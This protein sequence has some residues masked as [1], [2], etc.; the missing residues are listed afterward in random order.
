M[1]KAKDG[2]GIEPMTTRTA[3]ERSTAELS[4]LADE[5]EALQYRL[6]GINENT[7]GLWRLGFFSPAPMCP[8]HQSARFSKGSLIHCASSA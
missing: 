2:I 3:A 8:V 4:I 1:Q 7:F 5:S 6:T